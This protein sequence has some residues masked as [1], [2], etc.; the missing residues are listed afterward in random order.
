MKIL[1]PTNDCLT[2]APDF[3]NAKAFRLLTIINGSIKEDSFVTVE[4]DLRN[5]YPFGLK[6]LRDNGL[7]KINI[8]NT[9]NLKNKNK[10]N[11]QIAIVSGISSESEKNLQ[12]INYEVFHTEET[13]IFNALISYMK[14]HATMESDYCCCP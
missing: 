9:P 3:E 11:I 6:D 14:N 1:I 10:L 12:K 2:I 4:D 8:L 13:N 7:V 5:K